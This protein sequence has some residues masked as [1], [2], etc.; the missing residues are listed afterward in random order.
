M[1]DPRLEAYIMNTLKEW[2]DR[3]PELLQK[4]LNKMMKNNI[5]TAFGKFADTIN[6]IFH[7]NDGAKLKRILQKYYKGTVVNMK[8]DV[9]YTE[10]ISD[11]LKFFLSHKYKRLN[12]LDK[13]VLSSAITYLADYLSTFYHSKTIFEIATVSPRKELNDTIINSDELHSKRSGTI[14]PTLPLA[15]RNSL[16]EV[17]KDSSIEAPVKK[18]PESKPV[19]GVIQFD[20]H[21][22]IKVN[23][24]I[25]NNTTTTN[26][27]T[28]IDYYGNIR[29]DYTILPVQRN[30]R[31][32]YLGNVV[33][34]RHFRR[35]FVHGD[36]DDEFL[37]PIEDNT[38]TK[39][40]DHE[41]TGSSEVSKERR[42]SIPNRDKD[43]YYNLHYDDK[44]HMFDKKV[45]ESEEDSFMSQD[46][47][48]PN[49]MGHDAMALEGPPH[50]GRLSSLYRNFMKMA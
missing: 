42:Y 45:L 38:K 3:N 26:T 19:N 31:R 46:A 30:T 48:G 6:F 32:R 12:F 44:G 40:A 43:N 20:Q 49:V 10:M 7:K 33:D 4:D 39:T 37:Q 47:S 11:S 22:N 1:F 41:F 17:L 28:T 36:F 5:K 27:T 15:G 25:K 24:V 34:K 16:E 29:R 9:L 21:I 50:S 23:N 8:K 2:K 18:E 35:N 14:A 13:T